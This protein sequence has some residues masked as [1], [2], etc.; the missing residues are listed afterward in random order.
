MDACVC[1]RIVPVIMACAMVTI[2]GALP[3]CT[4]RA[5]RDGFEFSPLDPEDPTG[6][7]WRKKTIDGRCI[8]TNGKFC[9][10]CDRDTSEMVPC[11]DIL[12]LEN[13]PWS[14]DAV[15]TTPGGVGEARLESLREQFNELTLGMGGPAWLVFSG[16][17]QWKSGERVENVPLIVNY[18]TDADTP[19]DTSDD[20]LDATFVWYS[21]WRLP[22]VTNVPDGVKVWGVIDGVSGQKVAMGLRLSG[23]RDGVAFLLRDLGDDFH[24]TFEN[25]MEY[26][27]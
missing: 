17:D 15:A 7:I 11:E 16:W 27:E 23:P 13:A 12:R 2:Y 9:L 1:R 26:S 14:G 8:W 10:P 25:G 3:G 4:V 20:V 6:G 18:F 19:E 21:G 24:I 22:D 5:V